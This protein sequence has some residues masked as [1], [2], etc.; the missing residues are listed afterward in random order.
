MTEVN[1]RAIRI[2][3]IDLSLLID[4]LSIRESVKLFAGDSVREALAKLTDRTLRRLD[5]GEGE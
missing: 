4:E 5:V 2:G 1:P 3:H